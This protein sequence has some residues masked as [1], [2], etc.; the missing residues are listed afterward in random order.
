MGHPDGAHT[1]GGGSG[2]GTAVAVV[3]AVAVVAS[4]AGPVVH[5]AAELV[6]AVVI[7]AAVI[8]GLG[9]AAGAALVAWR[10]R[11]GRQNA[12]LV[13]HQ[14]RPVTRRPAESLP[15]PQRSAAPLPASNP[16]ATG[17]AA[18]LHLHFHGLTAEEAAAIVRHAHPGHQ[19]PDQHSPA[20]E[21][22]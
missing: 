9:L 10:L 16:A 14:A 4:I 7:A 21:E 2:I 13:V 8:L 6:R 12:P 11:R 22:G 5:A 15:V 19:S 20:I 1:H 18:E 17:Q 3:L